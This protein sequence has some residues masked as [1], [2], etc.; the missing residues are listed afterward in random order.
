M[1][2]RISYAIHESWE[3][4]MV[5]GGEYM[6][7]VTG[8]RAGS[9]FTNTVRVIDVPQ[10]KPKMVHVLSASKQLPDLGK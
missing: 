1:D 6:V 3:R 2:K 9:G 7:V 8:W 10:E 4:E 5:R